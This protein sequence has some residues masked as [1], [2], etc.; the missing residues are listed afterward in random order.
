[1]WFYAGQI[2]FMVRNR[3]QTLKLTANLCVQIWNATNDPLFGWISDKW[4]SDQ[5][6]R[7]GANS[8]ITSEFSFPLIGLGSYLCHTVWWILLGLGIH[9]DVDRVGRRF[10]LWFALCG[11][12]LP[13]R[14]VAHVC[15]GEP[16]CFTCRHYLRS[17]AAHIATS[18]VRH[19]R[20]NRLPVFSGSE[21]VLE[22]SALDGF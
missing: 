12:A 22:P 18:M 3:D 7:C 19:M 1:M 6:R 20:Y 4:R 8:T 10:T 9:R 11:D 17:I 14:R 21:G 16:L 15:R 13:L 2:V 5:V